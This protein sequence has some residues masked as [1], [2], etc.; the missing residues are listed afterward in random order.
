[1]NEVVARVR[2][3]ALIQKRREQIVSAARKV[4]HE[5]GYHRATV[6]DIGEC[7]KVTQGTLYNYMRR[8]EDILFL[9]C[10]ELVTQIQEFL[11]QAKARHKD[12]RD[13]LRAALRGLI[14]I[15]SRHQDDVLLMYHES[16]SLP[17][18]ALHSIL[19]RVHDYIEDFSSILRQGAKAGILPVSNPRLTANILTFIPTIVALRRWDLKHC[20]DRDVVFDEIVAFMMRALG[21]K[22]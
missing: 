21:G 8:K 6:R 11:Q 1:M 12:P 14:E 2:D 15:M 10:D 19:G 7:A 17:P 16:H 9:I 3:Q 20:G 4:F 18:E 13:R 22:E 5:K